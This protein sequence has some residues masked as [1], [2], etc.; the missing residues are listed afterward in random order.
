MM[1]YKEISLEPFTLV[2]IS[3]RTTNQNGQSQ[4]DI[5]N[6][7]IKFFNEQVIAGIPNKIS[8]DIYCMYTDYESNFMGEYTTLI[9]C[10]VSEVD[11][12]PEGLVS[13]HIP[14]SKYYEYRSEGKIPDCIGHTWMQI[15]QSP[16][17]N[18]KYE[19]DFDVYGSEAVNPESAVVYTYLSVK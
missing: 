9:G 4:T 17:D 5:N 11:K 8:D 1:I 12:I 14:E 13:K 16:D 7:W 2:G 18:R 10:K 6:L 19:A 15:W 3:V